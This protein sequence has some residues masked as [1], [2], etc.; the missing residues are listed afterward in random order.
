MKLVY[1]MA[2]FGLAI[3]AALIAGIKLVQQFNLSEE[4]PKKGKEKSKKAKIAGEYPFPG[5]MIPIAFCIGILPV[6]GF[7][8]PVRGAFLFLPAVMFLA[9]IGYGQDKQKLS[10]KMV[11]LAET[12]VILM[13]LASFSTSASFFGLPLPLDMGLAYLYMMLMIY[14]FKT[15]DQIENLVTVEAIILGFGLLCVAAMFPEQ[16][17][18]VPFICPLIG[19]LFVF[20]LFGRPPASLPL[21]S[22]GGAP[23]GFILGFLLLQIA[24]QGGNW[25]VIIIMPLLIL[26]DTVQ[27]VIRRII[28]KFPLLGIRGDS[29]LLRPFIQGAERKD[30]FKFIAKTML[31]FIF[32]GVLGV[33][34]GYAMPLWTLPVL[35]AMIGYHTFFKTRAWFWRKP[36]FKQSMKGT[37]NS[38]KEDIRSIK[39][40]AQ[41]GLDEVTNVTKVKKQS[42]QKGKRGKEKAHERTVTKPKTKQ[43]TKK[44]KA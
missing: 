3:V 40:E 6:L 20:C 19:A 33:Q 21:G 11:F 1:L 43:K 36:S 4:R 37:I 23:I 41:K 38:I 31:A 32:A 42:G 7:F 29:I 25:M 15:Q 10:G 9:F 14:A 28:D 22:V 13:G 24:A 16:R 8:T 12:V 34:A 27:I 30:V 5:A 2:V 26:M 44:K 35:C 18:L 17:M 39:K